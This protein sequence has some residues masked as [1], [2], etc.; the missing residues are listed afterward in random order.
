M[1]KKMIRKNVLIVLMAMAAGVN[2]PAAGLAEDQPLASGVTAG[3]PAATV[4]QAS[5]LQGTS[6]SQ[7]T[8]PKLKIERT[9]DGKFFLDFKGAPLINVLNVLSSLSGINFV[10]GK[11][12]A[13]RQ[14]NMTLD[15]ASL[16]DA[17]Q[18]IALGSNVTYE[19]LKDRKIYLFRASVDAADQ[20]ALMTKVFKFHYVRVV[21]PKDIQMDD[22]SSSSSGNSS[23]GS[24]SS[25]GLTTLKEET[26]VD[27]ESGSIFKIV[28]Q[29]AFRAGKSFSG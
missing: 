2:L 14:V 21:K 7:G 25:S 27:F 9:P 17:L 28:F 26:A 10:A 19:Y 8:T 24:S 18:S 22:T 15:N 1:I 29:N 13:E 16:E 4:P 20:P 23:S 5:R 3:N 12:V 11:E 6:K